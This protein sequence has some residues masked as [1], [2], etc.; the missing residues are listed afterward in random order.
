MTFLKFVSGSDEEE[1]EIEGGGGGGRWQGEERELRGKGKG[2]ERTRRVVIS[3]SV[4]TCYGSGDDVSWRWLRHC[5][6][7]SA[8]WCI[9][10]VLLISST[11]AA[12]LRPDT[13]IVGHTENGGELIQSVLLTTFPPLCLLTC[14]IRSNVF[15]LASSANTDSLFCVVGQYSKLNSV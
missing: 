1:S 2:N 12:Q 7:S 13:D 15:Q 10:F 11:A 4:C 9:L 6:S 8:L 14:V 3:G 5:R